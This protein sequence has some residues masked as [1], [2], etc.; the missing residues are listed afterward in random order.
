MVKAK[1]K[2]RMMERRAKDRRRKDGMGRG[3]NVCTR[4]VEGMVGL[5]RVQINKTCL[6][7]RWGTYLPDVG[8]REGESWK[9]SN[10]YTCEDRRGVGKEK[11]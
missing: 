9:E 7:R 8:R 10:K 6:E 1:N 5:G 3:S 11:N 4:L 2:M